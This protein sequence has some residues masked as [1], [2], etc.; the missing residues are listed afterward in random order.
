M[1]LLFPRQSIII[2]I[3]QVQLERGHGNFVNDQIRQIH[4]FPVESGR[5]TYHSARL[6]GLYMNLLFYI[7]RLLAD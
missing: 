7:G 5:C 1:N 6:F 4:S 3:G 2:F